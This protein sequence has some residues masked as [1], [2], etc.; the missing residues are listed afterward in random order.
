MPPRSA[1]RTWLLLGAAILLVGCVHESPEAAERTLSTIYPITAIRSEDPGSVATSPDVQDLWLRID[2]KQEPS[3][4]SQRSARVGVDRRRA[5]GDELSFRYGSPGASAASSP[6]ET[7]VTYRVRLTMQSDGPGEV[8]FEDEIPGG[9]TE[10]R[11]Q[12]I[13]LP[14]PGT[15]PWLVLEIDSGD[16]VLSAPAAWISPTLRGTRKAVSR[17]TPNVILVTIDTTR[18]DALDVYGGQAATPNISEL[19]EKGTTFEQAFSVAFGTAPSHASLFTASPSRIHRIYDNQTVLNSGFPVLAEALGDAGYST[20]AFVGSKVVSRSMGFSRG[21]DYFD[22]HFLPGNESTAVFSHYERRASV[23]VSRFLDWFEDSAPQPFFSWLHFYDPHQ[24]YAPP[25][26]DGGLV[27]RPEVLQYVN[28]EKGQARYVRMDQLKGVTPAARAEIELILRRRYIA[29]VEEVDRQIGR[30]ITALK[31]NDLFETTLIVVTA[32]HGEMLDERSPG[33][34]FRH[35]SILEPVAAVPLII[36]PPGNGEGRRQHA[37]VGSL[38]VAPTILDLVGID[39][40]SGWKGRSLARLVDG[41]PGRT[42]RRFLVV[43][44]AHEH[45]IAVYSENLYYR[46]LNEPDKRHP[47]YLEYPEE[48]WFELLPRHQVE[49]L[50]DSLDP[51]SDQF[52]LERVAAA[53]LDLKR[54]AGVDD[55]LT[56]LESKEH[57]EALKA[58]GY[59]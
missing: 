31:A 3:L 22:D 46:R 42:G 45:E 33:L 16:R 4:V 12:A 51:S 7:S 24:P 55:E 47:D 58:L 37:I 11:S 40:P 41:D 17:S 32:D 27:V 52:E 53:F 29:E 59:L 54:R 39:T 10:I 2:G 13:R 21:F 35:S 23:T 43:E 9:S 49:A 34:D 50:R 26:L 28:D 48:Q 8:V 25:G 30:I 5:Q 44:G 56:K 38:D 19:A 15:S 1:F 14:M 18:R 20:A 36:V 57:V 6:D